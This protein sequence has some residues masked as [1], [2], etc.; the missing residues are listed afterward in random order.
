[1]SRKLTQFVVIA[2]LS[3]MYVGTAF[4]SSP[5]DLNNNGTLDSEEVEVVVDTNA[6]LPAGEYT[7]KNLVITNAATLKLERNIDSPDFFKGVKINAENITID[8][9]AALSASYEL[10]NGANYGYGAPGESLYYSGASYGGV[11]RGNT[12][13]ST[14][15][16]ATKPTDLG[17]DG[18]YKG[19][20]AIW[21]AVSGTLTNNGQ[22]LAR[23]GQSAS[24]G[25]I[26]V[27]TK[28]IT[29]FGLF[30]A[31]GGNRF[32]WAYNKSPGGGGR[33]AIY[34]ETN[35]Y[36]GIAEAKGGCG[37]GFC[38]GNGTVG[39]FDTLNNNFST[40]ATW[41]FLKGDS[42]F[43]FN[44]ILITDGATVGGDEGSEISANELLVTQ[45]SSLSFS[46][47]QV[48]RI[49][50]I[51]I[52]TLSTLTFSGQENLTTDSLTVSGA[53][54]ITVLPEHILHLKIPTILV[55]PDS[56]ISAYGKGYDYGM[57]P[58]APVSEFAGASYGGVGYTNS[59]SSTYGSEREPTDFGSGGNGYKPRGGGAIRIESD[60]LTND[61]LITAEGLNTSSGGSIYITTNTMSGNGEI[62]ANGGGAY[63]SSRFYFMGGGGRIALYY[64][65]STYTGMITVL[66]GCASPDGATR[67]CAGDGTI[68]NEQLVSGISNILFLPGIQAS[69][70]YSEVGGVEERVWEPFGDDEVEML[71][72]TDTGESINE[73]YT[74]DIVDELPDGSN[75]YKG[76][77]QSLVDIDD[78]SGGPLVALF[79][80]DWRYDVF[81][82]VENGTK[83]NGGQVIKPTD[84]L[85]TLASTSLTDK[86][87]IIA[88][89]NGGLLAKAIMLKLKEEGKENLVDKVIFIAS[90]H[91]GTPKGLAA[92][93][94]G[95]DQQHALGIV[96]TD[97]KVRSVM[98]NMPGVYGLL[99]SETYISSLTESMISF[100][101]SSTTKPYR[102]AYGY[103]LTTMDEYTRFLNGIEGRVDAGDRINEP[104]VANT[105]MLTNALLAHKEKLDTWTAPE[106][107]EVFNIVGTG[108]KTPNS[109]EYGEFRESI[110][111]GCP[112]TLKV[113]PVLHFTNYGDE[114]VVSKSA[115]VADDT[116]KY[117]FDVGAFTKSDVS[118]T[119]YKHSNITETDSIQ[120][121]INDILH[122]SST[123]DIDFISNTE[124]EFTTNTDILTIHSP[125]RIYIRDAAG[126]ITGRTE[127]GGEWKSEIPESSYL[128]AG[129]V[130]Y[131]IVPSDLSYDIVI[132]GEGS[133]IYT[134]T[135]TT[136]SST[137]T[138][139]VHHTFTATV[140]PTMIVTYKKIGDTFSNAT[141]DANGD[142]TI[143]NEMNL[144][145]TIIEKVT[146]YADLTAAIRTLSLPKVYKTALLTLAARAEKLSTH[147]SKKLNRIA[148][149]V[150][151]ITIQKSVVRYEAKG[152]IT[153][154]ERLNI[155]T[156]IN[157]LM[158][159]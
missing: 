88:H 26:Y 30:N 35:T 74:K 111:E 41:Q 57:G 108:L 25:S 31:N 52:D 51:D 99:P 9:G 67:V 149:K 48:L 100:D 54:T 83:I 60:S 93:L 158:K 147:R 79:P 117:Y 49:P 143:D 36:T 81:D 155:D 110:C 68:V 128:E 50:K 20:G 156:I 2:Y 37:D 4:A 78:A 66:G 97:E 106:G 71:R 102:D 135:L 75:I 142:G 124:P 144:D 27:N 17:S 22:V 104:S 63:W 118:L 53:S 14:Y 86:V 96:S 34:Y 84:A 15:G 126:H 8:E 120:I 12:A 151:L 7:F 109:I 47:D 116:N 28:N 105:G 29:G 123:S 13:T 1:M 91:L 131:A 127:V 153:H 11:G 44:K 157:M 134:H 90:P 146:T 55:A 136:L 10:E 114:T 65:T 145:G 21:L 148:E 101:D 112:V 129:S 33:I 139:S 132:E 70:L 59:T 89:S 19:G 62:R 103:T 46:K 85:K 39:Y 119:K 61:G 115:V 76:F 94:H 5:L 23:G 82:I 137:E 69:R 122:G 113:E 133:G 45:G 152:M 64:Q 77:I 154:T 3:F 125:A 159:Q 42:P 98:Q 73:V 150:L 6:S 87:T 58:G 141:I 121:L 40:H 107:V 138:E 38:A 130:K 140:T 80:Y 56:V 95:Y 43:N 24:G 32:S 16:S 72:M 18:Y 92:L